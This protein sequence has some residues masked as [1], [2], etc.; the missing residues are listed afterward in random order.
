MKK[1]KM[2]YN[3]D[4]AEKTQEE[5]LKDQAED[6][7]WA[8]KDKHEM[9]RARTAAKLNWRVNK[10]KQCCDR[11]IPGWQYTRLMNDTRDNRHKYQ[12][13]SQDIAEQLTGKGQTDPVVQSV[14]ESNLKKVAFEKRRFQ[15][16]I[17]KTAAEIRRV[18]SLNMPD[19]DCTGL[20]I[21][22]DALESL[23]HQLDY[24]LERMSDIEESEAQLTENW[25]IERH[26]LAF[27]CHKP[28][29]SE[30]IA[31][32]KANRRRQK[33]AKRIRG[34]EQYKAHLASIRYPMNEE[35]VACGWRTL[36]DKRLMLSEKLNSMSM[37]VWHD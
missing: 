34:L 25:S 24:L 8:E 13:A 7:M 16:L 27:F 10:A 33:L 17:D 18:Q 12:P 9:R 28:Q 15:D 20:W 1:V 29:S 35:D 26:Q 36:Y 19:E 32:S 37:I 3:V 4:T 23:N 2:L 5:Y 11:K 30:Q 22:D 6:A 31:K 21:F 14:F